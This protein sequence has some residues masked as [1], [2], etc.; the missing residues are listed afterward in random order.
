VSAE[1]G[2]WGPREVADLLLR[3]YEIHEVM[4]EETGG[5]PG[6]RDAGLL[7]AAVARPFATYGGQE[8]YP[9]PLDKAAALFQSLL[10]SHPFVDG[11]KRTAFAAAL[12]LL[13]RYGAPLPSLLPQQEVVAFTLA[14]A[15]ES[16]PEMTVAEIAAWLRRVLR[17]EGW[18]A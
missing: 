7:H 14:M 3:V 4:I 17:L 1:A 16:R 10:K 9:T 18:Q 15:E 2:D 8:L 12:Y 11:A 5:T 6:L 13:D